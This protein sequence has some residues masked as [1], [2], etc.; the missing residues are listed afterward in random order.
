MFSIST[1]G[2]LWEGAKPSAS[3]MVI[4]FESD[5][6]SL[7]G[8]Q[9]GKLC[10]IFSAWG[11]YGTVCALRAQA[12]ERILS[13]LEHR[14]R[15][16]TTPDRQNQLHTFMYAK[17][18]IIIFENGKFQCFP[19]ELRY[20]PEISFQKNIFSQEKKCQYVKQIE[21]VS[22]QSKLSI[23]IENGKFQS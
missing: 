5:H 15:Q 6:S 3:A 7:V 18:S 12:H 23:I 1:Y 10:M 21:F 16:K 20:L 19:E 11:P 8:A 2:E 14:I 9:V 4:I 17:M 13:G 22:Q